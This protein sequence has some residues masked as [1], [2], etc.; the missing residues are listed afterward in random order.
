MTHAALGGNLGGSTS[1]LLSFDGGAA[2]GRLR[3]D[4]IYPVLGLKRCV[5]YQQGFEFTF[6]SSWLA[7]QTLLY[8][9]AQRGEQERS[10]QMRPIV[11]PSALSAQRAEERMQK[12]GVEP[13]AA[14][15]PAGSSGEKNVSVIAAPIYKGFTIQSLGGPQQSAKRFLASIAPPESGRTAVLIEASERQDALGTVYY[16]MEYTLEGPRFFRHNI[17]SYAS[18]DD[19]LFTLNA[20]CPESS[21]GEDSEDLRKAA[22][23]FKLFPSSSS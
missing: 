18:R 11:A 5:D 15:G 2:A 14:F 12:R 19:I 13:V 8:R 16:D 23:S 9:A 10:S 20:Q 1:K 21:W 6:P 22:A 4:V 7:D 17:S 3:L